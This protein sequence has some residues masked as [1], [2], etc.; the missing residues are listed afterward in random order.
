M[1]EWIQPVPM[2]AVFDLAII[3]GIVTALATAA[4][5]AYSIYANEENRDE[6]RKV[7]KK[8]LA[9]KE[10]A[11]DQSFAATRSFGEVQAQQQAAA[12]SNDGQLIQWGIV[13]VM[14]VA[15]LFVLAGKK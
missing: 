14:I 15:I 12:A 10:K 5:A 2:F 11:L 6:Q 3:A 13:G 7:V 1:L 9:L 8:E 4:G